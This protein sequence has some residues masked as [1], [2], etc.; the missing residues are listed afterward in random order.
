MIKFSR[1]RALIAMIPCLVI[2][3]LLSHLFAIYNHL[4]DSKPLV[5]KIAPPHPP[6]NYQYTNGS[7]LTQQEG[8]LA[9]KISWAAYH[10]TKVTS[11]EEEIYF[12]KI[13]RPNTTELEFSHLQLSKE[14]ADFGYKKCM[15]HELGYQMVPSFCWNSH[16]LFPGRK[17]R[18]PMDP[19][20]IFKGKWFHFTGDSIARYAFHG[21]RC[22]ITKHCNYPEDDSR[23]FR[24]PKSHK[25]VDFGHGFIKVEPINGIIISYSWA[26]FLKNIPIDLRKRFSKSKVKPD[27]VFIVAGLHDV[28]KANETEGEAKQ[29]SQL[30]ATELSK[31]MSEKVI[32]NVTFQSESPTRVEDSFMNT[33]IVDRLT[34]LYPM[35]L[36]ILDGHWPQPVNDQRDKI[37][38]LSHGHASGAR[39][40]WSY[41]WNIYGQINRLSPPPPAH[42]Q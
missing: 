41:L 5:Q 28:I 29:I 9:S 38:S 23:T 33:I 3:S 20:P 11:A 22:M 39:Y 2:L 15:E 24:Q 16:L 32:N 17:E 25:V 37:H 7:N 8:I 12:N 42:R 21:F 27:A 31:L 19:V 18:V 36:T 34:K 10:Q 35:G 6:T 13:R 40:A 4:Y 1:Q 14:E 26:P 30:F